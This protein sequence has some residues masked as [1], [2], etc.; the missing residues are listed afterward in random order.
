MIIQ[1]PKKKLYEKS[2][3]TKNELARLL[4]HPPFKAQ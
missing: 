2:G 4:L 1:L 3:V